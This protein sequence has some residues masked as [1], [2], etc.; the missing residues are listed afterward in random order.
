MSSTPKTA[1]L[2][3]PINRIWLVL[4]AATLASYGL[5]EHLTGST[6]HAWGVALVFALALA[7]GWGV[8]DVFM[9]LRTAPVLWR[10]VLL[11]WLLILTV[12]L[13]GLSLLA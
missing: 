7:K 8:A 5:G 11:G 12:S 6:W 9:G 2:H 1:W 4:V 3:T 10:R 13:A